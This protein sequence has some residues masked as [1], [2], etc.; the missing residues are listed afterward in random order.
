MTAGEALDRLLANEDQDIGSSSILVQRFVPDKYFTQAQYDRMK[1]LLGRRD[2]LDQAEST[3]LDN[4]LDQ[5]LDATVAR[6]DSILNS[7]SR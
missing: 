7:K 4:L 2:S 5:E 3:E 1:E 6:A